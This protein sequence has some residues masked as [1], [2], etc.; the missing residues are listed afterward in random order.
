M[1]INYNIIFND[2]HEDELRGEACF[3]KLK[4]FKG[5]IE[6]GVYSKPDEHEG[7]KGIKYVPEIH[8][9]QEAAVSYWTYLLS[10]PLWSEHLLDVRDVDDMLMG[11]VTVSANIEATRMLNTLSIFRHVQVFC[12]GVEL[13]HDLVKAGVNPDMAFMCSGLLHYDSG[14]VSARRSEDSEH[15]VLCHSAISLEDYKLYLGE[16]QETPPSNPADCKLTYVE[17]LKYYKGAIATWLSTKGRGAREETLLLTKL[18]PA[19]YTIQY[20]KEEKVVKSVT[21]N[22]DSVDKAGFGKLVE[23]LNK[24]HD[25]LVA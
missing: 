16:W 24:L 6:W 17:S 20:D 3:G 1:S 25:K 10:K 5:G 14:I 7:L 19:T 18:L 11:G 21:V 9:S 22:Q 8:C 15:T 12:D 4:D 23:N 13:F 2:G